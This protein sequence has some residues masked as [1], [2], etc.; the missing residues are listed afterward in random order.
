MFGGRIGFWEIALIVL[1]LLVFFGPKK[2]PELG[3]AIGS[4]LKE[5][6]KATKEMQETINEE[7]A[8]PAKA[9]EQVAKAS[10]A[11][12]ANGSNT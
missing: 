3:K 4:S 5:F 1:V 2:L 8:R 6:K 11:P 9:T 7:E 12:A 10:D